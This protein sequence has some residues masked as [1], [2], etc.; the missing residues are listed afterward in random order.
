MGGVVLPT[1]EEHEA[2]HVA[3]ADPA[4]ALG[5]GRTGRGLGLTWLHKYLGQEV[6]FDRSQA[7]PGRPPWVP[8]VWGWQP[9]ADGTQ[10]GP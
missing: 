8:A 9:T 7:R 6:R 4:S 2:Q 5:R 10:C 1:S 3:S